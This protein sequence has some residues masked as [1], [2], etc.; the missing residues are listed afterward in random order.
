LIARTVFSISTPE[1]VLGSV[2]AGATGAVLC[3]RLWH[4]SRAGR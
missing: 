1:T 2:V 3:L 4:S